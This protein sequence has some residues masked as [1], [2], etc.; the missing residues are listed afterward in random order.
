MRIGI[1]KKLIF[2]FLS[3][4]FLPIFAVLATANTSTIMA[5]AKIVFAL[6][7]PYSVCALI[8]VWILSSNILRPLYELVSAT[9]KITNG[10]YDFSISYDKNDEMGDLCVA[11]E[12]MREQLKTSMEKEAILESSRKELIASISH[13]LRTPMSSIKGY[14]EGLQDG[15]VHDKEKF[16]RYI[17]VIKN[18]TESLDNLIESLFL[19]SQ[20]DISDTKES[21]CIRESKELLESIISPIQIEFMDQPIQ[22][23]VVKPFPSVRLYANENS[24]AQVFDNLIS[25][26]K[27]YVGTNG[28]IRIETN[29]EGGYLKICII[30]NGTGI[31]EKDLPNIFDQFYRI[32]KSRS[33]N[34]GGTGLGLTICKRI[35]ENHNGKIWAEGSSSGGTEFCFTLPIH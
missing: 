5:V 9:Q 15:I 27:R 29:I 4:L 19:Y 1:R 31:P 13:D 3:M 16:D 11:F 20:L 10:N 35:I 28:L 30:D 8:L 24:I 12:L 25:N 34:F 23:E 33:R 6:L 7:I 22:L 32:E 2:S 21:L 17:T 18:K 26:A 14:V